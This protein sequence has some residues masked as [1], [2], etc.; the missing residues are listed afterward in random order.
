[1]EEARKML[2]AII[3]AQDV[4]LKYGFDGV[5]FTLDDLAEGFAKYY[6]L[7]YER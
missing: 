5:F 2:A 3:K 1:M 7:V 6:Y 4:A